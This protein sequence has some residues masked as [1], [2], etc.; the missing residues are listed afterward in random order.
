MKVIN[1]FGS[2]GAGKSTIASGLFYKM[3]LDGYKVELVTEFAKGLIYEDRLFCLNDQFYVTGVQNHYIHR[4][5]NKVD[6]VIT[7]SPILLGV[8][9]APLNYPDSFKKFIIDMFFTYDN[10]NI[11]LNRKFKF[12]KY[13]RKESEEESDRLS[14]VLKNM[15]NDYNVKFHEFDGDVT[16][17][18]KIYSLIIDEL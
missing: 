5:R 3:K 18:N 17:L 4:L 10:F 15:L 7:D 16:V 2:S 13:G 6:F 12:D 14:A 1:L 9:Y 11:F 8:L